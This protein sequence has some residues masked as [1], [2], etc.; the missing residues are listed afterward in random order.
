MT[1]IIWVGP[2]GVL[3]P[4]REV[5]NGGVYFVRWVL[6]DKVEHWSKVRQCLFMDTQVCLD[7]GYS[8]LEFNGW[9]PADW[10]PETGGGFRHVLGSWEPIV[11]DVIVR[12]ADLDDWPPEFINHL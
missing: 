8:V 3:W 7:Y 12:A 9:R 5:E 11:G 2:L 6:P 4:V 10:I 1:D